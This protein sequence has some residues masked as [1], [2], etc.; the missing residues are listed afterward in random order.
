M[1][2]CLRI[3]SLIMV[4]IIAFSAFSISASAKFYDKFMYELINDVDLSYEDEIKPCFYPEIFKGDSDIWHY[5]NMLYAHFNDSQTEPE[6]VVFIARTN[7]GQDESNVDRYVGD[8]FIWN[9]T[10]SYPYD[11]AHYVYVP[12]LQKVYTLE[13]ACNS[14][15]LDISAAM[16]SGRV[17]LHRGDIN[18]DRSCDILDA[19]IIQMHLASLDIDKEIMVGRMDLDG[20][21]DV[22]IIDAT[23]LQRYLARL[24]DYLVIETSSIEA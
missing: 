20:S 9:N 14:E 10:I 16:R 6:Y 4:V 21:D 7:V 24:D 1:K 18:F 22:S 5:Y 11:L 2:R 3:F 17:G 13:E 12:S 23:K 8:C 15:E 19:T